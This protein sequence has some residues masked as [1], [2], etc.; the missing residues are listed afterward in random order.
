MRRVILSAGLSVAMLF[1]AGPGLTQARP[2]PTAAKPADTKMALAKRVFDAMRFS[3]LIGKMLDDM[4][5]LMAMG[6]SSALSDKDSKLM[7]ESV[8]EAMMAKM[9]VYVD[10]MTK[11]YADTFTEE[12]LRAMAEF[13]ESPVGQSV[14]RKSANL[15]APATKAMMDLMPELLADTLTRFCSKTECNDSLKSRLRKL[16]S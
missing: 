5:P 15:T 6:E 7:R 1:S 3:E 2:A 8:R 4:D 14:L 9:P 10:A 13:Y 12:E 11:L 16:D